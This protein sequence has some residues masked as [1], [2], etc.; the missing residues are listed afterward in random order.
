MKKIIAARLLT[1]FL[2]EEKCKARIIVENYLLLA[3]YMTLTVKLNAQS[4]FFKDYSSTLKLSKVNSS[5]F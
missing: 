3:V 1:C 5:R 2:I 4:L